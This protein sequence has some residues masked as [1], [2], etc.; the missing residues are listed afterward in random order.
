MVEDVMHLLN[1]C[2]IPYIKAP[3]EAEAQC[4]ELE[5]MGLADGVVTEDSDGECK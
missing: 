1:I 5:K 3:A 4:T 2:G